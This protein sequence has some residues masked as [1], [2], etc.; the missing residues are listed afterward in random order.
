MTT[1]FTVLQNR[2]GKPI[3]FYELQCVL[4][5]TTRSIIAFYGNIYDTKKNCTAI[6]YE[7][8]CRRNGV[9]RK[10]NKLENAVCE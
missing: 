6:I 4:R 9:F 10:S 1:F 5:D 2:I 7:V 8:L 3:E